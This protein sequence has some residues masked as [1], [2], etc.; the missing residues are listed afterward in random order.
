MV[1]IC[2]GH[3]NSESA[4]KFANDLAAIQDVYVLY[5]QECGCSIN[6]DQLPSL[7]EKSKNFIFIHK[8]SQQKN[9]A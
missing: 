9:A 2:K 4:G 1:L 5:L 6:H 3:T 8:K 7:K